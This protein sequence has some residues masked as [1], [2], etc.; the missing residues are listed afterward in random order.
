MILVTGGAGLLGKELIQQLLQQGKTVKAIYNNT[1]IDIKHQNLTTVAC[2]I[3]DVV[4]VE[5]VFENITEVYHCAGLVS[6]APSDEQNLYNIN[7]QGTANIVNAC[8]EAK[9][10]KLIHV[11]SVAALGRIR[12][13]EQVNE[14]MQWTE[15]TSNSKYGQSKYLGEM[16]VWRAVAEGL[17]A[18]VICPSII[19]GCGNWEDG[20]SKLF[21]TAY[22]N[23]AWYSNGIT[24]FVDVADVAKAMIQLMQSNIENE[25]FILSAENKSYKD[26]LHS[27]AKKF[28]KKLASKEVTPFWA[29]IAWRAAAIASFF[30]GSKPLI[31]KETANTSL[32]KVFFDNSKLLKALPN[33]TYNNMEQS[34]SRICT[35]FTAKYLLTIN[36]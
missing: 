8:L 13:N 20:S 11:S 7:V 26:V 30:T 10:T 5:E 31:T 12:P 9:V 16:E 29:A 34:I 27:I 19:L 32:T 25:R 4:A 24:G 6:F 15:E 28:N 22:E 3:L 21:K 36:K 1:A 14:T 33:F 18:N 2:D 17:T 23:F 35:E